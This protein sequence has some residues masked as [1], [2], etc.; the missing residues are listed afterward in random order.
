VAIA[1]TRFH[2][3]ANGTA[4]TQL[5]EAAGIPGS[6]SIWADPLHEG[7]VPAGLTDSQ[8][9]DVRARY[10]GGPDGG[11]VDPV[12]DLREWRM[13]IERYSAYDELILWY[14][15]DLFDQLNLIQVL[16]WI[17][18]R[19][20]AEKEISL[21]CIGSFPDRPAFKG[22]GEL[23]PD[24][25]A[26]LL[27]EREHVGAAQFRLADR[28]WQAF[29][30][31][32]PEALDALRRTDTT[33]LPLLAAALTRLLEDYPWTGDGLS[34]TE[35]QLLRLA[36]AGVDNLASAFPRLHASEN[37]YYV[38]DVSLSALAEDLAAGSQPL[39]TLG[40]AAAGDQP[41]RR[42]IALTDAGGAVLAGAQDR[43]ALA[44]I[45]RWIGGVHLRADAPVWR[46]DDVEARVRQG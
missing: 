12:N 37:A 32:T 25:L 7:P 10:L 2:H 22:L 14:E 20:P 23:E 28:A 30:Q 36:A 33:A 16:S 43:L 29:R 11:A 34:R 17:C 45:D 44:A 1:A 41:L 6:W 3:V 38:T 19:V 35:R 21:I 5:I 18:A 31:P 13:A 15:H 42:S 46:W 9:L 27:P 26:S 24:E 4:T 39:L 40:P 8:L